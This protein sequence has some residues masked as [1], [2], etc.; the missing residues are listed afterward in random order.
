[1]RATGL[2]GAIAGARR[3]PIR[4]R[5]ASARMAFSPMGSIASSTRCMCRVFQANTALDR[6][7]RADDTAA[8]DASCRVQF[9]WDLAI[10]N[11]PLYGVNGLAAG[12][13]M[14]RF[15]AERGTGEIVDQEDRAK[16]PPEMHAGLIDWLTFR[17]CAEAHQRL[18]RRALPA[19]HRCR[20]PDQLV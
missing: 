5:V 19:L 12:H 4:A 8:S 20:D 13:G 10:V 17:R 6:K 2:R 16:Q 18:D 11:G 7:V 15:V 3:R 1:T 14:L 9:Q